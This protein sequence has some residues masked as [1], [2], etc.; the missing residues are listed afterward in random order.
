MLSSPIIRDRCAILLWLML[1]IQLVAS[2]VLVGGY[3]RLSDSGLSITEWKP[4]HGMI[5]PLNEE[6]WQEE[7]EAY[8]TTPQY[9]KINR[10]MSLIGFKAIFWPE[11][12]HRLLG[13][14]I[15]FAFLFPLLIFMVRRSISRKFFYRM[16]EILTLGGMQGGVGWIMVESGLQNTPYVSH[17]KLALHLSI[18]FSIFALIQWAILDI[19]NDNG[20]NNNAAKKAAPRLTEPFL[21]RP[22]VTY[23]MWL[24]LLCTQIIFGGF[25]AGLHAGLVYNTWPTMNGEFLPNDLINSSSLAINMLENITF[26]QFIHRILAVFV[27]ISFLFWCYSHRKYIMINYLYNICLFIALVI[28]I[29]FTLGVITLIYHVPLSL[30]LAH[31]MNALLLWAMSIC[32]LY[33]LTNCNNKQNI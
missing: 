22:S 20:T 27:A 13:R 28:F 23:K 5:P 14:I 16:A 9:K 25:M 7:F 2:M 10:D 3:T 24:F 17:T 32:L 30:A 8:K 31:Q 18:A 33:K 4:V 12:I 11:Y 19:I 21:K 1:C 15:G 26:I 6:Q 29:Q